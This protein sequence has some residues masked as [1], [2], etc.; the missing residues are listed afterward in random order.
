M[1]Q[2]IH[3]F[4]YYIH[5]NCYCVTDITNSNIRQKIF[6]KVKVMGKQVRK[7]VLTIGSLVTMLVEHLCV[8][9][10]DK[11]SSQQPWHVCTC[12]PWSL[13]VKQLQIHQQ[14]PFH[15]CCD[16]VT[17]HYQVYIIYSLYGELCLCWLGK[18][19]TLAFVT[20]MAR[21]SPTCGFFLHTMSQNYKL[22][23]QPQVQTA[24]RLIT[25]FAM[26]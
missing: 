4:Y 10:N 15:I 20:K 26:Q 11:L 18:D 13:Q 8:K 16:D 7:V 24:L 12:H 21:T 22:C 25:L 17:S 23:R 5:C 14:E 6:L 3:I 9:S 19:I 1:F 2:Y